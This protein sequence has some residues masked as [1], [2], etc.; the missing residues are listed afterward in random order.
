MNLEIDTADKILS[1]FDKLA[2]RLSFSI[3]LLSFSIIMVGLI[4][5][6]A[7]SGQ[8]TIIWNVPIIEIGTVIAIILFI[9]MFLSIFKSGRF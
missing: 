1:R 7:L 4:V 2:N 3:I 9:G 6:S 8:D 5:S